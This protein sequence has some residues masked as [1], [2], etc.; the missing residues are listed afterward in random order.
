MHVRV[1]FY[2]FRGIDVRCQEAL[3]VEVNRSSSR[4]IVLSVSP[5]ILV[6]P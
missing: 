5:L 1:G 4:D 6:R 2:G 3:S